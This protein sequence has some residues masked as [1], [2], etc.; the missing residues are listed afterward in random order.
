MCNWRASSV[1]AISIASARAPSGRAFLDEPTLARV[2]DELA[3][4]LAGAPH[5]LVISPEALVEVGDPLLQIVV[6]PQASLL[7]ARGLTGVIALL[8]EECVVGQMR[9]VLG[10]ART[11]GLAARARCAAGQHGKQAY[12]GHSQGGV[13]SYVGH[14][15][16]LADISCRRNCS[17]L[18]VPTLAAISYN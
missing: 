16:S 12:G 9:E 6:Q 13:V 4:D 14:V 11:G 7:L 10:E 15:C 17:A 2:R 1:G 8:D 18:A 5:A 3:V